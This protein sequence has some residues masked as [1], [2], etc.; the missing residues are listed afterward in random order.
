MCCYVNFK[1]PSLV[2]HCLWI[3]KL[4]SYNQTKPIFDSF[5]DNDW[6]KLLSTQ[7]TNVHLFSL[8]WLFLTSALSISFLK[9]IFNGLN[10]LTSKGCKAWDV[11]VSKVTNVFEPNS[12][13]C[14][15]ASN[16]TCDPCSFRIKRCW[17]DWKFSPKTN[18][19]L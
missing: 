12:Y 7:L 17:L 3:Q 5:L 16:L 8:P 14:A 19:F 9:A 11:W 2:I 6:S 18:D 10:Q 13:A 4:N 1:W 15:I